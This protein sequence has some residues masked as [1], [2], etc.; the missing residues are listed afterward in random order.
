[1]LLTASLSLPP[2]PTTHTTQ[3]CSHA[4]P[5]NL[6]IHFPS[7]VNPPQS[8]KHI[9]RHTHATPRLSRGSCLHTALSSRSNNSTHARQN[10][11]LSSLYSAGLRYRPVPVLSLSK[12]AAGPLSLSFAAASE[13]RGNNAALRAVALPGAAAPRYNINTL[14]TEQV[15]KILH[16]YI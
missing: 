14:D 7:L 11:A 3:L 2:H 15:K 6:T 16:A 5:S 12:G 9:S 1:M 10:K 8:L 13:R 4:S